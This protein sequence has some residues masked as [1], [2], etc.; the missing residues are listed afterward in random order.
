LLLYRH[1]DGTWDSDAIARYEEFKELHRSE[2]EQHG[3]D[4]L[5]VKEAYVLVLKKMSRYCRGLGLGLYH[6]RKVE[7]NSMRLGLNSQLRSRKCDKRKLHYMVKVG[8]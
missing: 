2:N 8:S 7:R 6:Q 1:K 3:V 4:N 5:H